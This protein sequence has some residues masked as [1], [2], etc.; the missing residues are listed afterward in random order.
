MAHLLE[1]YGADGVVARLH[2]SVADGTR[3]RAAACL[4]ALCHCN[5]ARDALVAYRAGAIEAILGVLETWPKEAELAE[6]AL[7]ALVHATGMGNFGGAPKLFDAALAT[8]ERHKTR[9]R[10]VQQSLRALHYVSLTLSVPPQA[11]RLAEGLAR[12]MCQWRRDDIIQ[13]YGAHLWIAIL[14]VEPK[15]IAIA[16]GELAT[17]TVHETAVQVAA[18]VTYHCV[19]VGGRP[20][21]GLVLNGLFPRLRSQD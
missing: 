4:G 2:E 12:V 10:V 5:A 21:H 7:S 3:G 8:L 1:R 11:P 20:W 9:L 18:G 6:L 19:S 14:A 16:H 15:D 17:R 13:W